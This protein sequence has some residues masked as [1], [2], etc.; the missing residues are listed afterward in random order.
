MELRWKRKDVFPVT[1]KRKWHWRKM[2][3]QQN[4]CSHDWMNWSKFRVL[5]ACDFIPLL[6]TLYKHV[7]QWLYSFNL[8]STEVHMQTHVHIYDVWHKRCR[9]R[10]VRID[11]WAY[12][13]T[14]KMKIYKMI[15][16]AVILGSFVLILVHQVDD[17]WILYQTDRLYLYIIY[18]K[19]YTCMWNYFLL[20]W[21]TQCWVLL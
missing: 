17:I 15:K 10:W 5:C 20:I 14:M 12:T 19:H 1:M 13:I 2:K 8:G 4:N 11:I 6:N 9:C 16:V 18:S 3:Q 21:S 7:S